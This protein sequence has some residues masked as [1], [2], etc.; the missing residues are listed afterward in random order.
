MKMLLLP[1][2]FI[3]CLRVDNPMSRDASGDTSSYF[4]NIDTEHVFYQK[5]SFNAHIY[6][7]KLAARKSF[8]KSVPLK[9]NKQMHDAG[10]L[11]L[12]N[13][14]F[15]FY[16]D[17]K[18]YNCT[19]KNKNLLREMPFDLANNCSNPDEDNSSISWKGCGN[20]TVKTFPSNEQASHITFKQYI[21]KLSCSYSLLIGHYAKLQRTYG[22]PSAGSQA[23]AKDS[24]SFEAADDYLKEKGITCE[25]HNGTLSLVFPEHEDEHE[26]YKSIRL[27]CGD[28][29][30]RLTV[31]MGL[32][33]KNSD[34]LAITIEPHR[35]DDEPTVYQAFDLDNQ[36]VIKKH[37][38]VVNTSGEIKKTVILDDYKKQE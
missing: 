5:K 3:A 2:L 29:I 25:E 21:H 9:A 32:V 15:K 1:L 23:Y 16:Q 13:I 26:D 38:Q 28:S 35:E 17:N 7:M 24:G 14:K 30:K 4:L 6:N 31:S 18:I 36:G 11:V 12:S 34:E 37:V 19:M 33:N 20:S 8:E 22:G 27:E 10:P